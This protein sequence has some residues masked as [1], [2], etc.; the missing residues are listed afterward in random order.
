MCDS[1]EERLYWARRVEQMRREKERAEER[2]KEKRTSTPA[3]PDAPEREGE[4]REPVPA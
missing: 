1:Y 2:K 4:R 3:K